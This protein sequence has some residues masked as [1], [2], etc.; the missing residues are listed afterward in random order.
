MTKGKRVLRKILKVFGWLI[1]SI[2]LLLIAIALAVQLP[3]VQNRLTQKAVAYLEK[4]IGTTVSLDHIS[5]SFPK[6]IVVEGLYFE[7][8]KKDTLL[9]A[10]KFSLNTDVF[11]LARKEIQ[12]NEIALENCKAYVNRPE[13]DSAYNFSYILKA[14]GG[15]STATPDTLEEKGW[16]FSLERIDLERINAKYHDYLTGNLVDLEL[17]EL[18]VSISEFDLENMKIVVD[19]INLS[20]TRTN[21]VQTK[22]PEVTEEVAE[23]Q[24]PFTYDIGVAKITLENI[25]GNF[26]QLALGKVIRL[27]VGRSELLTDKIDLKANRIDLNRF[28][29]LNSFLSV[30]QRKPPSPAPARQY[31][32]E[33][34]AEKK[35]EESKP[36]IIALNEL[37]LDGNSV[38]FYDFT[39]PYTAGTVDFDHL[40]LSA[41]NV[42]ARD[43]LINGGAVKVK[44]ENVSFREKSGFAIN[45]F[46]TIMD[47]ED[48]KISI[49]DLLLLTGNSKIQ[50]DAYATTPSF[51]NITQNY[52]QTKFNATIRNTA[53]GLRDILYFQP[54]LTDSLPLE[55][56]VN[57]KITIDGSI[58]GSVANI[59]IDYLRIHTLADTYL[60]TSG[61]IAGL[62]EMANVQMHMTIDKFYTSKR[63]MDLILPDTVI[64]ASI[65]VPKWISLQAK[66]DGSLK[67]SDF[68]ATMATDIGT[69][70]VAGKMNLDSASATRG[71]EATLLIKDLNVG[72]LLTKPDTIGTVNAEAYVNIHG[73]A[74]HELTGDI[75]LLVKNFE[76]YRYR[77]E[78]FRVDARILNGVYSG[79]ASLKDENLDFALEGALDYSDEVPRYKVK[80]DVRNA[81][82]KA[83]HLAERPL[84]A[85][86][87]LVT[88]I[89]TDDFKRLNGT[90]GIRKVAIFNGEALYAVDSLLFASLDEIG[91]SELK[92]DSDLLSGNFQGSFNVMSTA[93]VLKEYFSTY[94]S[95]H[96][97]TLAAK[98]NAPPQ[99]FNFSLKLKKTE[100]LTDILIPEL[101]SFVP[102]E[103]KGEFDSERKQLDLRIDIREIAYSRIGVKSFLLTTNSDASALNYDI[104]ADEVTIDSLKVDGI[105]FKGTVANDS[106][107]TSLVILDSTDRQKYILGGIFKSLADEYQLTLLPSEVRLN[108]VDWTVNPDNYLRFGGPKVVAKDIELANIRERITIDS[109]DDAASTLFIGFRELN[110]EYLV[111]MVSR[112]KPVSGLLHGDIFLVP[113]TGNMTFTADIGIKDLNISEIPW[114]DVTL[115]VGHESASRFDVRFAVSSDENDLRLKGYYV[116]GENPTIDLTAL[117]SR[118]SLASAEPLTM[119]QAKD[120]KGLLTGGFTIRGPVSKPLIDGTLN[121]DDVSFFSTY[122]KTPFSLDNET[123]SLTRTGIEFDDFNLLDNKKNKATIDGRI[124]TAHYKDFEFDLD[125]VTNNFRLLNTTEKDNELFY[126]RIDIDATIAIRGN[127]QEPSVTMQVGLGP[128]SHLTYIVPQSQAGVM[129]AE[130]IVRFVD[131]TFKGDA[132]MR[133]INPAD[134]VKSEFKG[135]HLI[136]RIELTDQETFTIIIDPTTGDQLTVRGNTTMTLNMDPTGD[137][138]LTGRYE[139]VDGTYNLSFYKFLKREFK[140]DKGS[141]MIWEGDPLNAQ[142]DISAIYKVETAPA[143]LFSSPLTGADQTELNKYK[144]RLPFQ[145]YLNMKGEL[146]KPE[147]SFRLDMPE[148]ERDYAEGNVYSRLMDINTRENDLNKQVFALLILKRFISDNPFESQASGS[149]EESA[150][151]SVSKLLTDQLNRLSEN[152]RGV[153]LSFDVKSYEDYS[154]GYGHEGQTQ[155]QLGLSKNLFNDRLVVKVAGNVGLEGESTAGDVTDYIGDIALEYKLTEDGRFRI[156]GFRNSN[157][158]MIDGELTETGTGLIYVKD[159]DLLS[160]L[161]KA[162]AQR[163]NK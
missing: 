76:Y 70:E 13:S 51:A 133:S 90:V 136:A 124:R 144:Q 143:D 82:F 147:I 84:R 48:K 117:I 4:K 81:N 32:P 109:R 134:T 99:H 18:E 162:N 16:K 138:D 152:I 100:L 62:P 65:E 37:D 104:V 20:D 7:D 129:E 49:S 156:T 61:V 91:K 71:Y 110:L 15:D 107:H 130:G 125:I 112:E 120:L 102:G 140:I 11:A 160:E 121:L 80:L 149:I 159:Y 135:L 92:I 5:I 158:D 1:L 44:L 145:V 40:W 155:L 93:D 153:E 47:F 79:S 2:I 8:Q 9:Y 53:I 31:D 163:K 103:I 54:F 64:P 43:L 132:F 137:M 96:D 56:P 113:D 22:Q 14:F 87:I 23:E 78:N 52:A 12:L 75:H 10:G 41:L 142:M 161:F 101:E 148:S 86:G 35:V 25:H 114:G 94:Y 105:E 33:P 39:K 50:I 28:S 66:Y 151:T 154:S 97:S 19:E 83:L 77:Y 85:R 127:T 150:R 58:K 106:I 74:F 122:L 6:T 57:A 72:T 128:N 29:L 139:I 68:R 131:K 60:K 38:Q 119:G 67:A 115:A 157:Y 73:L 108:Y 34:V 126:G 42:N 45:R 30:H 98:K 46:K 27:D 88:D 141:T 69:A 3:P 55:L 17:G 63:D 89:A 21:V 36:W 26:S 24:Q 95:L 146:L 116:A 111:S 118:F 123:I 59:N